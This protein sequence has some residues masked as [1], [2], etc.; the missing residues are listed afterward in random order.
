LSLTA[1][2]ELARA[3]D[4]RGRTALHLACAVKPGKPI[5]EEPN[6]IDTVGTLLECGSDL[7]AV[8]PMNE[9]EGDFRATPL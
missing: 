7:E 8:V 4:A 3:T 6:R 5:L 9:E 2:P 1:S